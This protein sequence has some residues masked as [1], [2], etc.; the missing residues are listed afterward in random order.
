MLML[1]TVILR[2]R[3]LIADTVLEHRSVVARAGHVWWGWWRK[4]N[5]PSRLGELEELRARVKDASLQVG[6]FDK[7]RQAFFVA[8]LDACVFDERGAFIPTPSPDTTPEYYRKQTLP[9]WF[10]M[11]HIQDVR[12]EAF[13]DHFGA[14]PVEDHT[15]YPVVIVSDAPRVEAPNVV[16]DVMPLRGSTILHLTDIHFGADFGFPPVRSPGLLPLL[17]IL[18]ADI[19]AVADEDI[20]L[21]VV[22]GDLT[23][24]GNASHLFNN[25]K[26]FLDELG[27]VFRLDPEYI[28]I[29]PGNHDIPVKDFALTYN[30]EAAFDAFL[31]NFYGATASQHRIFRFRLP[32]NRILEVLTISSVKLRSKE[33]SNYGWVDWQACEE[34]LATAGRPEPGSIRVAVLHHHLVSALREERLPDP[35]YPDGSVS[36]TLNAGAVIE[37]LQRHGFQ[38]VL[39]G[40]Q[41]TPGVNRISR[42]RL[43]RGSNTLHGIDEPLYV[44]AGGSAGVV[45]TRIDGD[46]RD[47][48]YGL[49]TVQGAELRLLVR[50]YASAGNVRDL[51][52]LAMRL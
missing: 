3:D 11:T 42:G 15:F 4:P 5:E 24:R 18:A 22:S 9:A 49:I 50:V 41:H 48:S 23:S 32:D 43:E 38:L 34:V 37:G 30:H 13:V 52:N 16:T 31:A 7:S 44:V 46:I 6:L 21:V 12:R 10:R 35:D 2:F 36:V 14:V 45:A 33:T 26:P 27:A 39:H 29:V 47:N 8:T 1:A 20:G 28:V 17:D 25:A 51:F 40:H 19:R